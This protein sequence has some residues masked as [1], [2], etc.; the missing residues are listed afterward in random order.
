MAKEAFF[1]LSTSLS[2]RK[3]N[4]AKKRRQKEEMRDMNTVGNIVIPS[5]FSKTFR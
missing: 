3:K 1:Q 4:W 5:N 2:P